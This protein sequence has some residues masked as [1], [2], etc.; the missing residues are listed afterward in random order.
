M[1]WLANSADEARPWHESEL[2]YCAMEVGCLARAPS[3]GW[4]QGI[5]GRFPELKA[6]RP[7]K[8]DPKRATHF[9]KAVFFDFQDMLDALEL[10]HGG[11]P[12]EHKWNTDETNAQYGGG[13]KNDGR[14]FITIRTR[15]RCYRLGSDNLQ[16]ATVV[17]CISAAGAI[18]PPSF[19]FAASSSETSTLSAPVPECADK[20]GLYVDFRFPFLMLVIA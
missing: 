10:E 20:I 7:V 15:K 5:R 19:V 16:M 8:L 3:R 1:D 14:K 4:L 18:C 12:P 17:E 11:I 13:R 6:S 2:R 9:N